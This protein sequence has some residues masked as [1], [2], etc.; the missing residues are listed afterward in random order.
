VSTLVERSAAEALT[1]A[2]AEDQ[3]QIQALIIG[4]QETSKHANIQ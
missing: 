3:P 2:H 4:D 1:R